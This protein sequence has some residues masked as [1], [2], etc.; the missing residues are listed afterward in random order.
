MD[1]LQKDIMNIYDPSR[2]ANWLVGPSGNAA[3]IAADHVTWEAGGLIEFW[4]TDSEGNQLLVAIAPL[5]HLVRRIMYTNVVT[6][7]THD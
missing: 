1:H 3:T 2:T 4:R 7:E 5:D 6:G